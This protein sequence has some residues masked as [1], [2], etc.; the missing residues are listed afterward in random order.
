M[1]EEED[2]EEEKEAVGD[3]K[4]EGDKSVP[5]SHLLKNFECGICLETLDMP[6]RLECDHYFCKHCL[7]NITKFNKRGICTI[8]CPNQVTLS[9]YTIY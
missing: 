8:K 3:K 7:D 6:R 5:V 4:E 9:Y 2:E 1:E